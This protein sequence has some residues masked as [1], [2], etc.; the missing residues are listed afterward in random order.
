MILS[1]AVSAVADNIVGISTVEG[2]P[3]DTVELQIGLTNTDNVSSVQVS[4]PLDPRLSLVENSAKTTGR[5]NGH[6]V[7]AGVKDGKLNVFVYSMSMGNIAAGNGTIATVKLKLGNEPSEISLSADKIVLTDSE[8]NTIGNTASTSGSATIRCAKATYSSM[9]I[10][11]G[12]V[13]IRS[14]YQQTVQ[15]SNVGNA[16]LSVSGVEFS[17][18]EFSCS[19]SFPMEIAAGG[20]RMFTLNYAP[21]ERGGIT[22][23]AKFITNSIY[24]LNTVKLQALPFAVNELHVE[25]VSGIADSIVTVSLRMNN[26]DPITGFQFDF[27]MPEQLEYI[28]GSFSLSNRKADHQLTVSMKNRMLRA[29]AFS[30]SDTPFSGNDGEIATFKVKLDGRYSTSLGAQKAILTANIKG[31]ETDVLSD[32]YS[33][34]VNILSPS[35]RCTDAISM[36]RT[37]ITQD[38][39]TTFCISNYGSAPLRIERI[40][41]S[42]DHLKV[43]NELP[44]VVDS[45]QSV[46]V[47]IVWNG[48]EEEDYNELLQLYT[49]DP[50]QRLHNIRI[51]GNRYSPNYITLSGTDVEPGDTLKLNVALSNNDIVNGLQYDLQYDKECFEFLDKSVWSDR[52]DGYSMTTRN[53]DNGKV[54]C[55]C[56]SLGG[57]EIAKGDGDVMTIL[58]TVKKETA[59][60]TYGFKVNNVLLSTPG[61]VNKYSGAG[62]DIVVNV[63]KP[64]RTISVSSSEH[65]NVNGCGTYDLGAVATLTAIPDEGYHF[66]SW[67]DGNTDNPRS[68]T[69]NTNITLAAS[70]APNSYTLKYVVDGEDYKTYTLEF[71]TPITAEENP[72]KEGY[73][74]S[75]WSA[76]PESMPAHDVTVEGIFKVNI[77]KVTWMIDGEII[78]VTEVEYGEEIIVPEVPKKEGYEF[79][80]WKDIPE[81]MPDTDITINGSYTPVSAIALIMAENKKV[82]VYT[83]NGNLV[84]NRM[85]LSE[86]MKLPNGIYIINGKK[87]IKQ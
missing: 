84:G 32:K 57:N 38:A 7:T 37:P 56:Y 81:T 35:M 27:N 26:M 54:R 77:H 51:T 31:K 13:P 5:T 85:V 12:R 60:G 33:G 65:G 67:S 62:N 29:L 86:I 44:I 18:T 72:T 34:Y 61:L 4:I 1:V 20:S 59:F 87:V 8:G 16:P 22:E 49:N 75:G 23:E 64:I 71:G 41:T 74:F 6:S 68:I 2:K 69:V 46:D 15:V 63:V 43:G 24:K 40:A 70:F 79:A 10:D 48:I 30:L 9:F 76:I 47:D 73:T 53:I 78:A 50:D 28:D 11:Y 19:E 66:V 55:F 45:W 39:K 82:N 52:A 21:V 80:G 83:I 25:D 17:A 42:S 14:S 58:F 36:G 3:G